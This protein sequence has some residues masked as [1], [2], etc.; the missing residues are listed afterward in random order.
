MVYAAGARI[1]AAGLNNNTMQLLA[2]STLTGSQA[3]IALN[4]PAGVSYN[5]LK[6]TWRVRGD[7]A[8]AAQQLYLRLNGDAGSNYLWEVLQANNTTVAG[9]TSAGT[10]TFIQIGTMTCASATALYFSSGD[11][12]ISG[13]IDT[14][15]YKVVCGKGS[16]FATT[17]NMWSGTFSGQWLS[18]S[19]VT[20]VSLVPQAGNFVAGSVMSL[21]GFE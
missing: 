21:Y 13:A 5:N 7:Q 10:S 19:A 4:I 14:T 2:T 8:S 12:E 9:T 18:A 20:S 17:T 6:V 3:S 16:A 11:C 15:N 1:T